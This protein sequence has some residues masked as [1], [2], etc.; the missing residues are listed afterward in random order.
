MD[1]FV[2][3]AAQHVYV[4]YARPRATGY[5]KSC[6]EKKNLRPPTP[7]PPPPTVS[8]VAADRFVQRSPGGE[9]VRILHRSV[10]AGL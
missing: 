9:R 6:T 4:I 3:D 2:A 10:H 1:G 7:S 8:T 5:R